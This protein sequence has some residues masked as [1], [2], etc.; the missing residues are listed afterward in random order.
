MASRLRG[1]RVDVGTNANDP[2]SSLAEGQLHYN[3]TSD[4]LK[5]YSQ[6]AWQAI[7]ATPPVFNTSSG[8]LGQAFTTA[9]PTFD[10]GVTDGETYSI[11]S[12][13]L[14]SGLSINSITGGA[15]ISGTVANNAAPDFGSNTSNFTV[16][17]TNGA[18]QAS[19]GFS[20]G[21]VSRFVGRECRQTNE[22]GN[23]SD[24]A[25]GNYFFV[26]KDFSSYGTPNGSCGSFSFGGCNSGSSS[27][28]DPTP[29][30]SYS[31]GANNG[32][33]GD[34][35]GGV[36]KRMYIQMSYGPQNV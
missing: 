11:T 24:T 21:I 17:A 14:P 9:S 5:V 27:S 25:P 8:S 3:T 26:R 10:I 19:R 6:G 30:R 34:P 2:S 4:T 16:A 32:R 28:Y 31:V 15:R 35:C 33:W 12:G 13:S 20:I 22:G 29:T 1:D 36:G 18:G 7:S 23:L